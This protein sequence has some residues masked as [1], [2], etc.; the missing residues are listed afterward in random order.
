MKKVSGIGIGS[1][2]YGIGY[3][4]Y[5]KQSIG[6]GIGIG[7]G[8]SIC[9]SIGHHGIVPSLIMGIKCGKLI[10]NLLTVCVHLGINVLDIL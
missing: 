4:R 1:G 8:I 7:I 9:I 2:H 6:I 10:V 5:S 3:R